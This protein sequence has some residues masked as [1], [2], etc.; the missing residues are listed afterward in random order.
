MHKDSLWGKEVWH[1]LLE[2]VTHLFTM[3]ESQ[4]ALAA[5]TVS[6]ETYVLG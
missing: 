1:P 5:S 2:R 6:P 3:G 4:H